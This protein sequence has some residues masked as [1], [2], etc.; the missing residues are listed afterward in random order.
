LKIETQL[1]MP[2]PDMIEQSCF[3]AS[4]M[5]MRKVKAQIELLAKVDVPVLISGESGSG[6]ETVARLIH[7]LSTR[8][9]NKFT[10]VNCA[11]LDGDSLQRELFGAVKDSATPGATGAFLLSDGGTVLLQ[12]IT[13]V[14]PRIQAQVLEVIQEHQ[15]GL[16][17]KVAPQVRILA[18]TGSAVESI[19]AHLRQDFYDR[20]SAFKIHLPPL[21]ERRE[22][23]KWLATHFM[24][25]LA[26]RHE[27][28][29]RPLSKN[30]LCAIEAHNW[31]GNLRELEIFIQ[32][33]VVIGNEQV[34]ISELPP[35]RSVGAAAVS[36]SSKGVQNTNE[37][38]TGLKS[39][40]R[41]VKS[42]AERNAIAEILGKTRWNRK[43]AARVLGI[44]YRSLLYKI[45][46]Y[47]LTPQVPGNAFKDNERTHYEG[48]TASPQELSDEEMSNNQSLPAGRSLRIGLVTSGS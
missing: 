20:L 26:K 39:L 16:R 35:T 44:S 47:Q 14:P 1:G 9:K 31:P 23:L 48:S 36:S 7:H 32:R 30:L 3:V 11:A 8:G 15:L 18:C 6:R 17:T 25:R 37:D 13:Y 5:A 28:A 42:E 38:T 40:V 2:E 22:E 12:E 4:S 43:E 41:S 24:D 29:P 46:H 10:R 45:E 27:I 34:A 19:Q 33:Y 21:R